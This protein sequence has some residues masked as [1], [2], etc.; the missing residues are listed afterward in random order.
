MSGTTDNPE[1]IQRLLAQAHE[2]GASGDWVGASVA[3][4]DAIH[5][6]RRRRD[7]AGMARA[8]GAYRNASAQVIE[9]AEHES[10]GAMIISRSADAPDPLCA[11]CYL[12]QPPMI[13]ADATRLREAAFAGGLPVRVLA[14]EPMTRDG[15]WPVVAVGD[16]IVRAKVEPPEKLQRVEGVITKDAYPGP[17]PLDWFRAAIGSLGETALSR[18]DADE[19][20]QHRVDDLLEI[21]SALPEHTGVLDALESAGAEAQQKPAPTLPRR[22]PVIDDP[23]SF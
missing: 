23:Y 1:P 19:P 20:P 16:V 10:D 7:F 12:L 13:G 6:A 14:R 4:L 9:L 17:A 21:L 5:D 2:A 18:L 8:I 22:R 11:G 3:A 15:L